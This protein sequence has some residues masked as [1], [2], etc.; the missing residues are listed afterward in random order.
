MRRQYVCGDDGDS[1]HL[2][3]PIQ[4]MRLCM[5][6]ILLAHTDFM[7]LINNNNKIS[8]DARL[9]SRSHVFFAICQ[10]FRTELY[11]DKMRRKLADG[12]CIHTDGVLFG[13][14]GGG[15]L[16]VWTLPKIVRQRDPIYPYVSYAIFT[17]H[18]LVCVQITRKS[19]AIYISAFLN[20]ALYCIEKC[21][22]VK[23][24]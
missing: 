6:Y 1:F 9:Y 12:L 19:R 4:Q 21:G 16:E 13:E 23:R 5:S 15:L 11:R 20:E 10:C 8:R 24:G 22:R 3:E 17:M 14:W 18:V 2:S 7:G